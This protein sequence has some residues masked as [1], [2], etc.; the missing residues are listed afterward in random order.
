M[1]LFTPTTSFAHVFGRPLCS[2]RRSPSQLHSRPN[3]FPRG[4]PVVR[5]LPLQIHSNINITMLILLISFRVHITPL[6]NFGLRSSFPLSFSFS[7]PL[8]LYCIFGLIRVLIPPV[9]PAQIFYSGFPPI[10][11][12]FLLPSFFF[13]CSVL[14]YVRPNSSLSFYCGSHCEFNSLLRFWST[15]TAVNP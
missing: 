12:V 5:C 9:K 2:R 13:A 7:F 4:V 1:L 11:V 10:Y 8:R 3:H 6:R 15:S 14:P